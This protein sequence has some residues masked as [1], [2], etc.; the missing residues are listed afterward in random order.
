MKLWR[1]A[2]DLLRRHGKC[3]MIT[4]VEVKGS[5]PRDPGAR[6]I[7]TEDGFYRG[8]IGGGALEW[9][10]M[11]R[12]QS[13]LASG[14]GRSH[15]T[16]AALGPDL[17]AEAYPLR[18]VRQQEIIAVMADKSGTFALQHVGQHRVLMNVCHKD[19]AAL[20]FRKRVGQIHTRSP[21]R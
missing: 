14:D 13:A 12:A 4:I 18:V 17:D 16:W 3:A 5:S 8:T 11:A 2:Q 20:R 19:P 6:L 15:L 21:M 10:A 7:V 9:Q 1:T